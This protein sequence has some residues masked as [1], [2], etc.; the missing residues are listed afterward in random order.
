VSHRVVLRHKRGSVVHRTVSHCIP[1][2]RIVS[3]RV[4]LRHKRSSI[5][6]RIVSR[7]IPLRRIVSR[8][9]VSHHKRSSVVCRFTLHLIP[10]ASCRVASCRIA[11]CCVTSVAASSVA[12][13]RI[14]SHPIALHRIASHRIMSCR[15]LSHRIVLRHRRSC[16]GWGRNR[17]R[18]RQSG[19]SR[20]YFFD[21]GGTIVYLFSCRCR[22]GCGGIIVTI[23]AIVFGRKIGRGEHHLLTSTRS[24]D[25]R[26]WG[27]IDRGGGYARVG[28][29]A[30]WPLASVAS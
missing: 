26:Q 16:C 29:Y 7:C 14:A 9:V 28:G 15:V 11:S 3:P 1:L 18:R 25:D 4:V 2:R 17:W 20:C 13:C 12:S 24:R 5:V 10:V 27:L 22:C 30:R 6:H 8:C 19:G 23:D 21:V